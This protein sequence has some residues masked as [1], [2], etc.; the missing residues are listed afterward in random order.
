MTNENKT[1][2]AVN[3]ITC[4]TYFF[5]VRHALRSY[6][7]DLDVAAVACGLG[8]AI[9]NKVTGFLEFQNEVDYTND[10]IIH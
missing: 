3:K 7:G 6:V 5:R 9:G 4:P 2:C 8:R 1:R 10:K